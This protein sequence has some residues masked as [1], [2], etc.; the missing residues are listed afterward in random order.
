MRK[1]DAGGLLIET[2]G[3]PLMLIPL[4]IGGK[5]GDGLMKYALIAASDYPLV[6]DRKWHANWNPRVKAFYAG[7]SALVSEGRGERYLHRLILGLGS[8]DRREADHANRTTL[9]N[10][11]VNL[12]IATSSQNNANQGART[13]RSGFRGVGQAPSR[14]WQA[15]IGID[16]RQQY[17]GSFVTPEAAAAAYDR[18]ARELHGSFARPNAVE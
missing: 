8:G 1:Q 12:R 3:A 17:L 7:T 11:R 13:A 16:G 9:D 2:R 14:R 15:R 6:K 18:A 5:H 4:S 10:R